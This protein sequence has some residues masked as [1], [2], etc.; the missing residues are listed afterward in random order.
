VQPI[1]VHVRRRDRLAPARLA[2][3]E[4]IHAANMADRIMQ[5]HRDARAE[6]RGDHGVRLGH[7][8]VLALDDRDALGGLHERHQL[9]SP[10]TR[11]IFS[12]NAAGANGFT[13]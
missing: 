12:F 4:V 5:A 7:N 6:Q 2:E 10:N 13:T 8:R 11:S 1:A 9:S 3:Q